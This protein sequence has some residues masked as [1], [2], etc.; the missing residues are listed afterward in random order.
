MG[1]KKIAKDLK[2]HLRKATVSVSALRALKTAG[3]RLEALGEPED[4]TAADLPEAASAMTE[5]LRALAD[6]YPKAVIGMMRYMVKRSIGDADKKAE[7][8]QI[9][10]KA[11][12]D[13]DFTIHIGDD[14][15][16][17]A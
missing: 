10:D 7:F 1:L 3:L 16:R 9:L 11:M 5:L 17:S 6:V 2:K 15:E 8:L 13:G 14:P 12:N 4:L